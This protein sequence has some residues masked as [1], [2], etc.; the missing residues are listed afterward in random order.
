[1]TPRA[2]EVLAACDAVVAEDTRYTGQLLKHLGIGKKRFHSLPAYDE[3]HRADP[4][5]E[6]LAQGAS[7]ALVTDAG[8]PAISDPGAAL[9]RRAVERGVGVV[10]VPGAS[11]P[12]N[13]RVT[14]ATAAEHLDTSQLASS[15]SRHTGWRRR[16]AT[17]SRRWGIAQRSSRG[18]SRSCTKSS[19]AALSASWRRGSRE[20][21]AARSSSS[22]KAPRRRKRKT[23]RTSNRTCGSDSHEASGRKTSPRL[24]PRA[25]RSATCINSRSS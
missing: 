24:S 15:T 20:T 11:A 25:T 23:R 17:W 1:M 22:L 3:A 13:G 10:P 5:V 21:C 12:S 14:P 4:I 16:S 9:V 6:R 8:T 18:S 7:F 19:R 2:R